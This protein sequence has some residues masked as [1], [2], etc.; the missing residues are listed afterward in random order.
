MQAVFGNK[1]KT[2]R[3]KKNFQKGTKLYQLHKYAKVRFSGIPSGEPHLN[4]ADNVAVAD[5]VGRRL[6]RQH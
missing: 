6:S 5:V 4:K 3:P 1:H 2:F